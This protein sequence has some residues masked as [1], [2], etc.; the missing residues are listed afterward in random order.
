MGN[1]RWRLETSINLA[2]LHAKEADFL[3]QLEIIISD[4]GS[5]FPLS[6]VLSLVPEAT[7]RVKFV[8]IPPELSQKEQKD[9]KFPEVIALNAAARRAT[10][11]Y[12]GRIDNDTIVGKEFY[13]KFVNCIDNKSNLWFKPEDV[14]MFVERRSI[15]YRISHKSF[16]LFY[17]ENYLKW[18]GEKLKIESAREWG[19][20]FWWSPVGIMIFHRKIWE[21]AGGYDEKLIYW[22]WMEGDLALRLAQKH[23]LIDFK[24]L[25]G[26]HLYHLEHYSNLIDYKDRN[27]PATPRKKNSPVFDKL[28]Y[29]E[30]DENWGLFD[31]NIRANLYKHSDV[32]KY[33]SPVEYSFGGKFSFIPRITVAI[34]YHEVDNIVEGIKLSLRNIKSKIKIKLGYIKIITR[35]KFRN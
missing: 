14:F 19:L 23:H 5:E 3:E 24:D 25:V 26:N 20:P 22:G 33:K 29:S 30:N 18:F 1:S 9:S 15:P 12:I 8:H 4:W 16:P 11:D 21:N 31:F 10:G 28:K 34:L 32:R 2:L 7:G 27:G 13:S 17:I 35:E 6:E